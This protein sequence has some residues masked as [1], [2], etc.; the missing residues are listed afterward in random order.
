MSTSG[1]PKADSSSSCKATLWSSVR[2]SSAS[3][4]TSTSEPG[5]A[6]PLALDPNSQRATLGGP[7]GNL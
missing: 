6:R 7:A 1:S 3:K 4:A 5:P 2:G